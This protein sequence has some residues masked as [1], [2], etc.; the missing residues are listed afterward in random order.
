[1]ENRMPLVSMVMPCYN[2]CDKMER[3]LKS[4]LRQTY[5]HIE[6]IFVDDGSTDGTGELINSYRDRL[7]DAGMSVIYLYQENRGLGGAVNRGL[8]EMH[9]DYLT[10]PDPD[11]W[12]SDDSVEKKL[13]FL[14]EHPE[15]GIVTSNAY[16]YD[17][18]DVTHPIGKIVSRVTDNTRQD[19]QFELLLRYRS[20]FCPGCH[21]VRMSAFRDANPEC[22]IYESRGGQ[23]FQML[24]PVYYR[25][26][27]YFLDEPLYNYVIY[28]DSH[29]RGDNTLE[30]KIR[31]LDG[32]LDIIL[33]T[34]ARIPM[35]SD[36]RE[37]YEKMVETDDAGRRLI[38]AF[39]YGDRVLLKNS[40]AKLCDLGTPS[41]EQKIKYFMI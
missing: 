31:R 21:M 16:V 28:S 36:E 20:V 24:L 30:K 14:E 13:R 9:G 32:L 5:R 26:K 34:L 37:K 7:T 6:V 15:Y 10:W 23:N 33:S 11:D 41:R 22:D 27:R 25:Y 29:S 35:S 40:Y 38:A 3:M 12:L 19:N 4:L 8:K 2:V 1:M 18:K 39:Q 17:E